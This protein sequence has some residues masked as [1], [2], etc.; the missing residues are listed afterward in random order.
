MTSFNIE[1]LAFFVGLFLAWLVWRQFR[2]YLLHSYRDS[3]FDLRYELFLLA[4][5][6]DLLQNMVYRRIREILNGKIYTADSVGIMWVLSFWNIFKENEFQNNAI[7]FYESLRSDIKELPADLEKKIEQIFEKTQGRFVLFLF[8]RSLIGIAL[9]V[10]LLGIILVLLVFIIIQAKTEQ[11]IK[12]ANAISNK[13]NNYP[14]YA[15]SS[16]SPI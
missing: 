5:E 6:N 10:I 14:D 11:F 12:R 2:T 3:L 13:I 8:S 15:F 16:N 7:K 9:L 4:V 1:P